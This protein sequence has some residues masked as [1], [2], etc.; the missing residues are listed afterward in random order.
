[1]ERALTN[2]TIKM[3]GSRRVLPTT[4]MASPRNGHLG[5]WV[6]GLG[7]NSPVPST[8]LQL[9]ILNES[10]TVVRR[11][12]QIKGECIDPGYV[13]FFLSHRCRPAVHEMPIVDID[14]D[15]NIAKVIHPDFTRSLGPDL[16]FRLQAEWA[17]E[18]G[19]PEYAL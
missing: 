14:R 6:L 12:E 16:F 4:G 18:H 5:V 11:F 17:R 9:A 13:D 8:R 15:G 10:G 7:P 2:R 19:K 3:N 1:M